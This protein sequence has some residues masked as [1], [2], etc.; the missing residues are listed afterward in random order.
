VATKSLVPAAK[1]NFLKLK[2][3][4]CL[5][6][7]GPPSPHYPDKCSKIGVLQI[8]KA[9]RHYTPDLSKIR[10]DDKSTE[11]LAAI[12]NAG[13]NLTDS[14]Q[15]MIAYLLVTQGPL[16]KFGLRI[17]QPLYINLPP[18]LGMPRE[19]RL[20]LEKLDLNYLDQWY[21]GY[22]IGAV[23]AAEG[24][25]E[26]YISPSKG[27]KPDPYTIT[28][29]LTDKLPSYVL[30]WRDFKIKK[31]ELEKKGRKKLPPDVRKK[32]TKILE[33]P[34]KQKASADDVPTIDTV[35]E[36]WLDSRPSVPGL[37]FERKGKTKL[38]KVER[39]LIEAKSKKAKL[40]T[41]KNGRVVMNG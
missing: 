41:G 20:T 6:H 18:Y 8:A 14:Q 9:C 17:G 22:I 29:K 39:D 3:G 33:A 26:I 1:D 32:I 15:R 5:H 40:K 16:K 37:K 13:K 38:H 30:P 27:G 19:R 28:L 2:C 24:A 35:P 10:R 31:H 11:L 7:K 4:D 12:A 36:A 21:K 23:Q 25:V 34:F